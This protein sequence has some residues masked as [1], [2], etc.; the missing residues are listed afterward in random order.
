[1]SWR[2][3]TVTQEPDRQLSRAD[4]SDV[5]PGPVP[6][7]RIALWQGTLQASAAPTDL[8]VGWVIGGKRI[9]GGIDEP[10][11]PRVWLDDEQLPPVGGWAPVPQEPGPGFAPTVTWRNPYSTQSQWFA[12]DTNDLDA[13]GITGATIDGV[14]RSAS[15]WLE[16]GGVAIQVQGPTAPAAAPNIILHHPL[17]DFSAPGKTIL[18]PMTITSITPNAVQR[19]GHGG[20]VITIKGT[21]F[22]GPLR[23]VTGGNAG[24]TWA[25]TVIDDETVEAIPPDPAYNINGNYGIN[26]QRIGQTGDQVSSAP[27]NLVNFTA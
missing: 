22:H 19:I 8:G 21:N 23:V 18:P 5:T 15:S 27:G 16:G 12:G 20:P 4:L 6:E 13:V 25:T 17:G 7:S 9:M 26:V 10:G 3:V 14:S 24:F 11:E 1:M 2:K